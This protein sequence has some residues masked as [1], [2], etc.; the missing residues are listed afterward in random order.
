MWDLAE[1]LAVERLILVKLLMAS[2]RMGEA[3]DVG[4]VFDSPA[5]LIHL[6]VLGESLRLR[7]EA[8]RVMRYEDL[9]RRLS[10]RLERVHL[11]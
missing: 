11:R 10:T 7:L 1:P 9:A 8:A 2:G 5:P 3:L 6:L 4:A